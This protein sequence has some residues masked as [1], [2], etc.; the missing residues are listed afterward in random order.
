M[1][2][3]ASMKLDGN[4]VF[5]DCGRFRY[6]LVR[7][8]DAALPRLCYVCL[9]PSTAGKTAEDASSRKFLGFAK[10]LGFGSYVTVN[11]YAWIATK[12]AEL[13]R[14]GYPVGPDNDAHI[15][16]AARSASDVICAWGSNAKG[17]SRPSDVLDLI[18]RS[19]RR[20]LALR[21]NSDGTPA[22]PLMLPYA[23]RPEPFQ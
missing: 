13:K 4:A 15:E 7:E 21:I 8:W 9:N 5:S 2:A 6:L 23:A 1:K 17:L 16:A 20:P 11:L 19:G 14:A 3:T 10:R 12:P 18:A 22:H